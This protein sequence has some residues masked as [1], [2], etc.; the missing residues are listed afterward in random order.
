VNITLEQVRESAKKIVEAN[1]DLIY[2]QTEE[3]KNYGTCKY[4]RF[5]EPSC[6][7]GQVLARLGVPVEVLAELDEQSD[8]SINGED[9]PTVLFNAGFEVSN[10]AYRYM[11]EAQAVQ[12]R[13][14]RPNTW[15]E[16]LAR[17][18]GRVS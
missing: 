15:G 16:A 9:V 6:L 11:A 13:T 3:F 8:G 12:D 5:G 10:D 17:A 2:T 18:E 1:P 14:S 7:V 4:E